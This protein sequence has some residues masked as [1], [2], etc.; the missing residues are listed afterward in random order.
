MYLL[1]K[2]NAYNLAYSYSY[3]I[4]LPPWATL[5]VLFYER[6]GPWVVLWDMKL[7]HKG[8]LRY[9]ALCSMACT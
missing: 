8:S 5:I 7:S 9:R 2:P 1:Y 4:I 3:L 6:Y